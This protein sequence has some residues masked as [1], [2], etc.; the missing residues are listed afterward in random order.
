MS[1][2]SNFGSIIS[3]LSIQ[4]YH[5]I[6]KADHHI[7]TAYDKHPERTGRNISNREKYSIKIEYKKKLKKIADILDG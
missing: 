3:K 6:D 1:D 7:G 5:H 4:N 2:N